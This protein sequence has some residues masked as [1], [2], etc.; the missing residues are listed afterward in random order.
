[1]KQHWV[2]LIFTYTFTLGSHFV[3][4]NDDEASC[5]LKCGLQKYFT[6]L[7]WYSH[8][9][10]RKKKYVLNGEVNTKLDI[11]QFMILCMYAWDMVQTSTYPHTYFYYADIIARK[12]SSVCVNWI[13]VHVR[14]HF[15]WYSFEHGKHSI[16]L[17]VL[18]YAFQIA[19]S[20]NKYLVAG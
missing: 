19:L 7:Q 11:N 14:S 18:W 12:M 6:N 9:R 15:T 20:K 17:V 3:I 16:D 5:Q 4:S 13:L 1:M 10:F 2:A 8:M